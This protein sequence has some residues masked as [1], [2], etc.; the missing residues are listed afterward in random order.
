MC[1]PLPD[2][3]LS[4]LSSIAPMQGLFSY[5]VNMIG[6]FG[7]WVFAKKKLVRNAGVDLF[8]GELS[9]STVPK[10]YAR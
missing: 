10:F 9:Y 8:P 2:S 5:V 6:L 4:S 1:P 3:M 7:G